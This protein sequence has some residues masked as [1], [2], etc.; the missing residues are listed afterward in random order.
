MSEY[1]Q[2]QLKQRTTTDSYANLHNLQGYLEKFDFLYFNLQ[3]KNTGG[4]NAAHVR[5]QGSFNGTDWILLG[6][7]NQA[8]AAGATLTLRT[9]IPDY[10]PYVRVQ[11]KSAVVG[12]QTTVKAVA[13]AL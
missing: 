8:I 13:F 9:T 12:A 7:D 4:T 2:F 3:L 5:F 6:A 10:Y 11:I 1:K